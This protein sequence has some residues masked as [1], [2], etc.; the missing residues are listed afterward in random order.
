MV[1]ISV[2][3][4]I[5]VVLIE[6]VVGKEVVVLDSSWHPKAKNKKNKLKNTTRKCFNSYSILL[7]ICLNGGTNKVAVE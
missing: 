6:V 3:V 7:K 2:V 1:V 5:V 4:S